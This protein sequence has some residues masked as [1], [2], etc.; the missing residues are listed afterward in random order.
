MNYTRNTVEAVL[1]DYCNL[2]AQAKLLAA[3]YCKRQDIS[4][5]AISIRGISSEEIIFDV[6][7]Y[8]KY[9]DSRIQNVILG[10]PTSQLYGTD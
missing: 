8:G 4:Y 9:P 2:E 6:N 5:D 10:I 7:S 3:E 1:T